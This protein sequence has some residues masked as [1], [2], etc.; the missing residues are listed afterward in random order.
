[1][2]TKLFNTIFFTL[3]SLITFSQKAGPVLVSV[4]QQEPTCSRYSDG[5]ITITPSGGVAPYQYLWSTGDT[6]ETIDSLLAGNYSVSVIDAT[7]QTTATFITLVD[8]LPIFIVGQSQNTQIGQSNGLIDIID[9][10]NP[11]GNWTW[12]WA[13][14]NGYQLD[15]SLLDQSGLPSGNYKI[16]VTDERG[17]QG[18]GY[19]SINGFFKPTFTPNIINSINNNPSA[20]STYPN[21]SNGNFTIEAKDEISEIRIVN[22]VT[23]L[24]VFKSVDTW[25]K[26]QFNELQKGDYIIWTTVGSEVQMER[27]SVL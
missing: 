9:V 11:V 15:Q 12:T 5:W 27:I 24:E 18:I 16:I 3:L 2:K 17:C 10:V 25:D 23:G 19:Y 1:M 7:G 13:S 26:I 20:I 8:P 21:P 6:T 14:N 4:T 22:I